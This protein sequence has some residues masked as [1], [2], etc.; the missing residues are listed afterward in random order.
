MACPGW[1]C[2]NVIFAHWLFS[3]CVGV[4][5]TFNV[6]SNNQSTGSDNRRALEAFFFFLPHNA[7][8]PFNFVINI[9]ESQAH[10]NWIALI[11]IKGYF[12]TVMGHTTITLC[13]INAGGRANE[14][15]SPLMKIK[16]LCINNVWSRDSKKKPS[17][18]TLCC[19]KVCH[20]RWCLTCNEQ[21]K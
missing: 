18:D 12:K 3:Y 8:L 21:K 4:I 2:D 15:A 13:L 1:K 20:C 6:S 7:Y 10:L 11:L 5:V 16:R 19:C 9:H 14:H 17:T